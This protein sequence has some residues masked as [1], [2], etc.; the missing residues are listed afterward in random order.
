M[1][2]QNSINNT[3]PN[4]DFSV[5]RTDAGTD[6]SLSSNHSDNTNASSNAIILA[7]AG[8]A[9][10]GDA[11]N[12][13]NI[14]SAQDYSMGIDNSD[15]DIL[16]MTNHDTPS[17][18]NTLWQ[19][20]NTGQRLLP[21]QCSFFAR[22]SADAIAVTGN[23]AS[24]V[25][26]STGTVTTEVDRNSNFD[27]VSTFTA[28]IDGLY[29]L[30]CHVRCVNVML[31]VSG[32]VFEFTAGGRIYSSGTLTYMPTSSQIVDLQNTSIAP[33]S[34]TDTVICTLSLSGLPGNTIDVQGQVN[35]VSSFSAFLLG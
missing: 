18:G 11:F 26:G 16:K 27:G 25:W 20:D 4:N 10:G 2:S 30:C 7:Q 8:G 28:P 34:E 12:R 19:M 15:S 6:V 9:S 14:V 33:L 29:L 23:G 22:M 5:N 3:V 1:V 24:W 35:P 31:N 21:R 32:G 17:S 13:W